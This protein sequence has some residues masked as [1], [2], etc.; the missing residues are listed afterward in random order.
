[1]KKLILIAIILIAHLSISGQR[2]NSLILE[3]ANVIDID[4]GKIQRLNIKLKNG[5]I[6]KI[7]KKRIRGGRKINLNGKFVIPHLWDMHVHIQ[8]DKTKLEKLADY[9]VLGVRDAGTFERENLVSLIKWSSSDYSKEF[10]PKIYNAGF[11]HNGSSCQVK[12]HETVD[13]KTDLEKAFSFQKEKDIKFFKVHNCFPD[14]LLKNLGKLGKKENIRVFGHIPEG[15]DPIEYA[16]MNVSSIEHIDIILRAL[17]FRK[18][19]P[20]PLPEGVKLLDG[21]YL[22]DLAEVLIENKVALTPTLVTYENFIKTLPEKQR[23]RAI[24]ILK[25]LQKYTKR[26]SDKGVF[27]LAGTDLGLPGIEPGKSLIRELELMVESGLTPTEALKT[28]TINPA[29][30]LGIKNLPISKGNPA[31]FIILDKNPLK[32]IEHLKEIDSIVKNGSIKILRKNT[33]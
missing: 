26:L 24:P 20:L 1:M 32:K 2:S 12:M 29:K 3:N 4:S 21:K 17:A 25:R 7:S 11:I 13:T 27:L 28:A 16:K 33:N 30:Y 15:I 6:S 5:R 10:I 14:S 8:G 19:N 18:N 9:G 22:D 31:D 23:P